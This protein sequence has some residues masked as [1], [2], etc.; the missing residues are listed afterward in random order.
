M[1]Y[2]IHF[3]VSE[4]FQDLQRSSDLIGP[5]R[6]TYRI[7]YRVLQPLLGH[8]PTWRPLHPRPE[9]F[10]LGR[11]RQLWCYRRT[12]E[13]V[14]ADLLS[15][16]GQRRLGHGAGEAAGPRRTARSETGESG[17]CWVGEWMKVGEERNGTNSMTN[18]SS[19][20]LESLVEVN[21]F[22]ILQI[23][24][25]PRIPRSPKTIF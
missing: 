23:F 5:Y 22:G 1:P 24:V 14:G 19:V 3:H 4:L 20:V 13:G 11:G 21:D 7:V 12:S 10:D 17:C 8:L 6:G 16:L 25:H 15:Q 18:C 9:S 2:A